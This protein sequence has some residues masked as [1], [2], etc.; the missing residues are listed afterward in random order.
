MNKG[1]NAIENVWK[2][3]KPFLLCTLTPQQSTQ[4][5]S[6]SK[7]W[8]EGSP[9][10]SNHFSPG[11]PAECPP[12]QSQHYLPG[13]SIRSHSGR[14]QSHRLPLPHRIPGTNPGLLNFWPN[15]LKLGLPRP[16]FQFN[17]FARM[18]H[19]TQRNTYLHLLVYYKG[20]YKGYRWRGLQS[21]EGG[22]VTDFS[23]PPREKYHPGTSTC[24]A[25]RKLP[26]PPASWVFMQASLHRHEWLS[27]WPLVIN[28][29]SPSSFSPPPRLGVGLKVPTL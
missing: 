28:L 2:N 16:L 20:C 23:C 1:K 22:R 8:G 5:S 15:C 7:C 12:V 25:I 26:K 24:P 11:T 21:Q 6:V 4:K 14:A 13:N 17:Y 10:T 9:L 29:T 19:R 3:S 18:A 27:H